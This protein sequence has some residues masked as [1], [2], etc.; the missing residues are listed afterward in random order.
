M[1]KEEFLRKFDDITESIIRNK[2]KMDSRQEQ[3]KS[4][5]DKLNKEYNDLIE[6]HRLYFVAVKDLKEVSGLVREVDFETN[7]YS[8]HSNVKS[9][10][11]L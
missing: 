4:K 1:V 3:E 5:L 8:H 9:T 10:N 7:F 11:N 2:F 6:N